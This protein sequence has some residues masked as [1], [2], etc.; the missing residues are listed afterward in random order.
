MS[1]L[2]GVADCVKNASG[3]EEE[4]H[5]NMFLLTVKFRLRIHMWHSITLDSLN[6]LIA[7]SLVEV[8]VRC[9][10]LFEALRIEP[11]KWLLEPWGN[12]GGG[13]WVVAVCGKWAVW[14]NDIEEGFNFSRFHSWGN[15]GE[16]WCDNLEL[17]HVLNRI[18]SKIDSS[19]PCT[20]EF[21]SLRP[22]L[23]L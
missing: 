21:S 10:N 19:E 15:L 8:D 23:P 1:H 13:F 7:D 4:T 5:K 16:Y 18:Q 12:E 14:Y 20:F 6:T 17:K 2:L 11:E 22:P 3:A 9:C